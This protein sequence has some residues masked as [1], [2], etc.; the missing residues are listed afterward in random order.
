M[1][2]NRDVL[3]GFLALFCLW[4]GLECGYRIGR[5]SEAYSHALYVVRVVQAERTMK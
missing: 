3:I 5:E 1:P 4:I 2:I